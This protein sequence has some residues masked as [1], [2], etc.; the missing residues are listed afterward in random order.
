[1]S[2]YPCLFVGIGSNNTVGSG[3]L[4]KMP[5]VRPSKHNLSCRTPG[6]KRARLPKGIAALPHIAT[7]YLQ[8][9]NR[10][11]R[12][13]IVRVAALGL[14]AAMVMGSW[15]LWVHRLRVDEVLNRL[16]RH[17][18][19]TAVLAGIVT[20]AFVSH[21]RSVHA[22][23]TPR[24]WLAALP[25]SPRIRR[26]EALALQVGP[27]LAMMVLICGLG[28]L[29]SAMLALGGLSAKSG[30]VAW[31]SLLLG[32]FLGVGGGLIVPHPR[33]VSPYPGSRYVPHRAAPGRHPVPSLAGLAIWPIRSMFA[34]LRPKTLSRTLLPVLI[35]MPLGTTAASGMVWIGIFIAWAAL[36]SLIA[37]VGSVFRAARRW[38]K[39]L[40]LPVGRLGFAISR[41]AVVVILGIGAVAAWLRWVARL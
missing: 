30:L 16:Q 12:V 35:M 37:S 25:I 34:M 20:A 10:F 41:R 32:T 21:R 36:L 9:S 33:P 24:S 14:L 8:C 2:R 3:K 39:P 5:G 6:F 19:M 4:H 28:L 22:A 15:I 13:P 26:I 1:M 23:R 27:V 7:R 29:T 18:V 11:E 31:R 38:L 17:T 40:P